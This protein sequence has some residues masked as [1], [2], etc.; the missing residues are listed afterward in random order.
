MVE[1]VLDR[2]CQLAR[3]LGV[4]VA[5]TA[6]SWSWA[7]DWVYTIRPGDELWSLAAKYCGSSSFA[8]DL[9]A[10]NQLED[11]TAIRAGSRLRIPVAWLVRAPANAVL[12]DRIGDVELVT[13]NGASAA[14]VGVEVHMGMRLRTA[15]GSA[16]VRF[17]DGST[18]RVA[19]NSDVLFNVLTVFGDTGMVDTH[20]RYYSGRGEA[21]IRRQATGSRFRVST[22]SGVAAVRGTAFRV[23]VEAEATRSETTRGEI[24]FA[25]SSGTQSVPAGFGVVASSAGI[26]REALLPA[27]AVN[28][29]TGALAQAEQFGWSAVA[30]AVSYRVTL[31]EA[32]R[33]GVIVR[34]ETRADPQTGF[35]TVPAGEYL[36][37]V[38]A[39][40]ASGL[41]G[42]DS[43]VPVR[44]ASPGPVLA[45]V[46]LQSVGAARLTWSEGRAPFDVRLGS[47]DGATEQRTSTARYLDV[48]DLPPGRYQV[49]VRGSDT[50]FGEA[51]EFSVSPGE[52]TT[53]THTLSERDARLDWQAASGAE[54][55]RVVVSR[56]RGNRSVEVFAQDV[57]GTTLT[58]P[59]RRGNRYSV[60][61]TPLGGGLQGPS[62]QH[63]FDSAPLSRWWLLSTLL[64]LLAL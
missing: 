47:A 55:Y 1:P 32:S 21:D 49:S 7:E 33:P 13:A 30:G 26:D 31:A 27:P 34:D 9:A 3:W 14:E 56:S 38:R 51:A 60:T 5:L 42:F 28:A 53:A 19:A 25:N 29:P 45:P 44:I 35:A 46:A 16:S 8:D 23:A 39:I 22:P 52:I 6:T 18:L 36:L 43:S 64:P 48:S 63:A 17:A 58:F 62:A 4:V 59:V 50:A 61:I 2:V 40:A 11:P 12:V 10:H 41:E 57:T 20:L 37:A 54:S 24:G 15:D